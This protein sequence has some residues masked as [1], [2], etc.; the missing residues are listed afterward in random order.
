MSSAARQRIG[1][2]ILLGTAILGNSRYAILQEPFD[3]RTSGPRPPSGPPPLLRLKLGDTVEGF[4]LSEI[5][6]KKVVFT[7]G[8]SRVEIPLDFSRKVEEP[9]RKAPAVAPT[10][11]RLPSRSRTPSQPGAV[12]APRASP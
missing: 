2:L 8:A 6:A 4:K 9:A 5:D 1:R 11:P 3:A 7:K 12:P 10:P